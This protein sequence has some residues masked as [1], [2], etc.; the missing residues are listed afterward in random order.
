MSGLPAEEVECTGR[1]GAPAQELLA[2]WLDSQCCA[3][4]GHFLKPGAILGKIAQFRALEGSPI[5]II[6]RTL[7]SELRSHV[8]DE[9]SRFAVCEGR[10]VS[11]KIAAKQSY[12]VPSTLPSNKMLVDR[13]TQ[14]SLEKDA[15]EMR[16]LRKG[17]KKIASEQHRFSLLGKARARRRRRRRRSRSHLEH[18]RR[19]RRQALRLSRSRVSGS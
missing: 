7:I 10:P 4:H 19:P 13:R 6:P 5:E 9:P 8:A 12:L 18:E 11:F 1:A 3:T 15:A 16:A 17:L 14:A 2:R